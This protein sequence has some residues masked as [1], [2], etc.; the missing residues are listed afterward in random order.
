MK[1]LRCGTRLRTRRT[2]PPRSNGRD[3]VP[4]SAPRT[5]NQRSAIRREC[6]RAMSGYAFG[7]LGWRGARS[8]VEA[9]CLQHSAAPIQRPTM[10]ET[11]RKVSPC[12]GSSC[13]CTSRTSS[14]TARSR[15]SSPTSWRY[16]PPTD[17]TVSA[18]AISR[19]GRAAKPARAAGRSRAR[20]RKRSPAGRWWTRWHTCVRT[21]RAARSPR[22]RSR[23]RSRWPGGTSFGF[24][25]SSISLFHEPLRFEDGAITM[26][27]GYRPSLD[28][29]RIAAHTTA[30]EVFEA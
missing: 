21:P 23:P 14:R 17:G 9:Q 22:P 8:Y 15:S 27:A 19:R 4:S 28:P 13:R 24:L 29:D 2:P 3:A 5:S 10:T 20:W 1:A 11:I 16:P 18:T 25:K 30:C 26:P 12:G 6:V 7:T